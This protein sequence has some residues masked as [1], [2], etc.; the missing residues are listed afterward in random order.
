MPCSERRI[1]HATRGLQ[2]Q[3]KAFTT[4]LKATV[5]KQSGS[6]FK[7]FNSF[8][9]ETPGSID[10]IVADEA[11]R[12]RVSSNS[13]FTPAAKRSTRAQVEELLDLAKVSVFLL[14]EQQVVRPGEVGTPDLIEQAAAAKGMRVDVIELDGQFRC[15]GSVG[16]LEWLSHVL[17]L[18]GSSDTSWR[19]EYDFRVVDS[20]AALEADLQAKIGQKFT[21]RMVA[22]FCWKWSDPDAQNALLPDVVLGDW[23]RPWNRKE[24]GGEPPQRHPY[25]LWAKEKSGFNEIGCIYSVQGFEFDYTGVIFGNDLVNRDGAWVAIKGNSHDKT[26][27][28]S[29]ELATL[30]IGRAHV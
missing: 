16:Y 3:P 11:H 17:G 13:R 18:G 24:K 14:D 25:T 15:S 28:T 1:Q 8:S 22:G 10:V 6:F 20:P 21:A 7:Y 26:V 12:L 9:Q 23:A 5:S 4:N 27:K 30:Q 2:A 19:G 29:K